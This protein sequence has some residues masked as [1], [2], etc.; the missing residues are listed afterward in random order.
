M[1]KSTVERFLSEPWGLTDG[2]GMGEVREI[3]D[4]RVTTKIYFSRALI[5]I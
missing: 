4:S 1:E 3:K 2:L 5:F